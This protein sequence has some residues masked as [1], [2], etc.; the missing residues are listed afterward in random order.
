MVLGKWDQRGALSRASSCTGVCG[1]SVFVLAG[2][3]L[4]RYLA[5]VQRVEISTYWVLSYLLSC[6]TLQSLIAA[7]PFMFGTQR[8]SYG[9]QASVILV[10]SHL[11]M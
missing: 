3:C 11:E 1:S 8:Q 4:E 6:L 9:L 2:M 10:C 5:I 7:L